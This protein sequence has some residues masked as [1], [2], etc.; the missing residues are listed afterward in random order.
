MGDDDDSFSTVAGGGYV[1]KA[2]GSKSAKGGAKH[3]GMWSNP[4]DIYFALESIAPTSSAMLTQLI[5]LRAVWVVPGDRAYQ[6]LS[7]ISADRK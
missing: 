2:I 4:G 7:G 5:P 6:G 1:K 3:V